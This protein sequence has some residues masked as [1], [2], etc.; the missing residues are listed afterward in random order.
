MSGKNDAQ[1]LDELHKSEQKL[2]D[3]L[4]EQLDRVRDTLLTNTVRR[5]LTVIALGSQRQSY[6][7]G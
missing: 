4:R 1:V 6:L 2:T 5:S 7:G 3:S